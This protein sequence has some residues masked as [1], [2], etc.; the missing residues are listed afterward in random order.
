MQIN[1]CL[2]IAA[3]PV[4]LIA[5]VATSVCA[6]QAP[7]F[8]QKADANHDGYISRDELRA[9]MAG[10]LAG[11]GRATQAQLSGALE[12]AFPE[13]AF[14]QMISPPQTR[15]PKPEDVQKMMAALPSSAP[16]K[17]MKPRKMLVLCKCA[18]FIHSCIPLAAKTIEELGSRTGAWSTTVSSDSS[19]ITA[20]N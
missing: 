9:A 14:M 8:I 2:T 12:A 20:E 15:T 10:W 19:V 4:A 11:Q 3:A 7:D 13:S 1:Q 17:P 5:I 6:Q 18:G 16:A